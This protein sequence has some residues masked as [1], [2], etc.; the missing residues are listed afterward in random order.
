M[1]S[2]LAKAG[3]RQGIRPLTEGKTKVFQ[4]VSCIVA[5]QPVEIMAHIRTNAGILNG[6]L[7]ELLSSLNSPKFNPPRLTRGFETTAES[8]MDGLVGL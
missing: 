3:D 7:A 4:H 1:M 8:Y 2:P 6:S 5:C